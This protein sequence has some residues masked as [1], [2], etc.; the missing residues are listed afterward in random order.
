M[1]CRH[2]RHGTS[3][4]DARRHRLCIR[5]QRE[6][7]MGWQDG[8]RPSRRHQTERKR[9]REDFGRAPARPFVVHRL[10][11]GWTIPR[12]PWPCWWRTARASARRAAAP[13]A[14]KVID[15]YL[16]GPD[17]VTETKKPAGA[18][19]SPV[20]HTPAC[21]HGCRA[22]STNLSWAEN[23][24]LTSPHGEKASEPHQKLSCR[25]PSFRGSK[26]GRRSARRPAADRRRLPLILFAGAEVRLLLLPIPGQSHPHGAD[27]AQPG[28]SS[29]TAT[30]PS[31]RTIC[32]HFKSNWCESRLAT[33]RP[34]T[35]RWPQLV[36]IGLL[37]PRGSREH[38]PH[39]DASQGLRKRPHQ[40]AA[41]RGGDGVIRRASLSILGGGHPHSTCP[42][43]SSR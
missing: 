41:E 3:G 14:R 16:L 18:P 12:S 22:P 17:A 33:P 1:G 35:P 27:T 38:S 10:R 37:R 20:A 11:T 23:L 24:R 4:L 32:R 6:I 26:R 30:A 31:S 28:G 13:I 36:A 21:A 43:L 29:S 40:V 15:A 39:R 9:P 7:Q 8:D 25:E 34:W 19:A 2:R 5:S 42:P